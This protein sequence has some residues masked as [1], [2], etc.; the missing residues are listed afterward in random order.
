[1]ILDFGKPPNRWIRSL[2]DRYLK[3]VQPALGWLFF[4]DA[5]T[6]RYIHESLVR[7]PAQEGVCRLL[8]EA[9]FKEV[10]YDHLFLGTMSLHTATK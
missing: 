10:R 6:Y 2:Y 4:G 1:M 3:T 7:Y 8:N 9:H 5:E